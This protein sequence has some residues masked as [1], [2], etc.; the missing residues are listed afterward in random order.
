MSIF[1]DDYDTPDGTC[2]RD[3]IH[4]SDLADAHVLTLE[5]ILQKK[6]NLTLNC[7]YGHGYS[8]RQVLDV[9]RQLADHP[10]SINIASR[11]A[12]DVAV[13]VADTRKIRQRLGWVPHFDDLHVIIESAL[14]W[15]RVKAGMKTPEFS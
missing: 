15:E 4:V 7:G 12:G 11:R 8:V 14:N 5:H 13:L 10:L 2:I 9:V 3:Y 6:Q 1:G